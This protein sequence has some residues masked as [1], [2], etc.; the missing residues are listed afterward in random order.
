MYRLARGKS[1]GFRTS[2]S[3]WSED[4]YTSLSLGTHALQKMQHP[5]VFKKKSIGFV[6]IYK[7]GLMSFAIGNRIGHEN[8]LVIINVGAGGGGEVSTF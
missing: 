6:W 8:L 1:G 4:S 2:S 7:S 3:V 5:I